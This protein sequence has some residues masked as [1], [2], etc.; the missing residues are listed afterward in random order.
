MARFRKT[1]FT[2]IELLVVIAIIAILIALLLPA[3]QQAR[4]AARRTQC[5]NNLK[6]IGLALHNYHDV[7]QMFPPAMIGALLSPRGLP[8]DW[9][10]SDDPDNNRGVYINYL[11]MLLPYLDQAA[12]YNNINHDAQCMGRWGGGGSPPCYTRNDVEVWEVYLPSLS[13]PSD[14]NSN[15]ANLCTTNGVRLAR[16]NYAAVGSDTTLNSTSFT[17]QFW[18]RLS[19]ANRGFMGVAG[20]ARVQDVVDGTSNT[21]AVLEVRA[22]SDANDP[23]GVW[24]WGIGMTIWGAGGINTGIDQIRECRDDAVSGMPCLGENSS[25][26]QNG[27]LNLVSRSMHEGGVH[28]LLADGS[29]RFLSENLD[30]SL[31][32]ALRAIADH[33]VVGEF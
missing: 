1:G 19:R 22:A 17:G 26:A 20:A 10:I 4:E 2:L 33:V 8:V 18:M 28:G 29:V 5:R 30:A 16:G 31:Y 23:R 9:S 32:D 21:L 14:P 15:G 24:A 25:P 6:Q 27:D 12:M 3:V 13:C 7:N 11:G